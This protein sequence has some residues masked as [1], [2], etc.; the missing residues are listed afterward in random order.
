M[1]QGKAGTGVPRGGDGGWIER[2]TR[3]EG[4]GDKKKAF[5]GIIMRSK[6]LGDNK[7]AYRGIPRYFEG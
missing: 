3:F 6:G 4:L 1:G 2:K 7:K 5:R